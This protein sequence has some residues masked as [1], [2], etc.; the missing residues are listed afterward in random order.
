MMFYAHFCKGA[1]LLSKF[2]GS[3]HGKSAIVSLGVHVQY[4][5]KKYA[6]YISVVREPHRN[7]ESCWY[8]VYTTTIPRSDDILVKIGSMN[9]ILRRSAT[10]SKTEFGLTANSRR[11]LRK[12][13]DPQKWFTG[14]IPG[15]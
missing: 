1:K 7:G 5:R 2:A 14:R 3:E 9:I 10:G 15:A 6:F 12:L 13:P 8:I 11:S 4:S